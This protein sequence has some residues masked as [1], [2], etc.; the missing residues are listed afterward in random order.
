MPAPRHHHIQRI[1]TE[2]NNTHAWLVRVQ[3]RNRS[4]TRYFSDNLYAGK[5]PA[6]Q[7]AVRYRDTVLLSLD[8]R[9]Y[10]L[11]RRNRKRRNNTSGIVGVGRYV[12]CERK[13][14]RQ[15]ERIY[16]HAFWDGSDGR[17]RSRKFSINLYGEHRARE[18]ACQ[19]RSQALRELTAVTSVYALGRIKTRRWDNSNPR[20]R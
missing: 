4:V 10:P 19:A 6:L 11:W 18:L 12:S 8:D 13:G 1:D 20:K 14:K 2:R 3:R 5:R 7:A 16:W 9:R 17:R 15:I